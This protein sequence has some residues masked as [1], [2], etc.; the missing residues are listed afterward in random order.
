ML[1]AQGTKPVT[2]EEGQAVAKE[3]KA[4]KYV[5]CSSKNGEGVQDVFDTALREASKKR[6]GK[7]KVARK[8]LVL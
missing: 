6:W 4:V 8:C 7:R 3:I 5:E 2:A 1:S